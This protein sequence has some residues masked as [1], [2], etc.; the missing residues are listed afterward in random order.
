MHV[1]Q[2]IEE[3]TVN[4]YYVSLWC[5]VTSMVSG[6]SQERTIGR[7]LEKLSLCSPLDPMNKSNTAWQ[8]YCTHLDSVLHADFSIAQAT[9]NAQ[10]LFN[11]FRILSLEKSLDGYRSLCWAASYFTQWNKYLIQWI[12]WEYLLQWGVRKAIQAQ[13]HFANL[14]QTGLFS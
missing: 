4:K 11:E 10:N 9:D 12:C 2:G 1:S 3:C 14:N 7:P 13:A 5:D 8:L 6:R